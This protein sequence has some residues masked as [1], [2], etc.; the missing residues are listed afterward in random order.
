[1]IDS[2]DPTAHAAGRDVLAA[3][4]VAGV[5]S[6][7]PSTLGALARGTD[8]LQSSRAA[9]SLLIGENRSD[10]A[11]M[12][13]AIPVHATLTLGW[14]AVLA[15]TLP[16]GREPVWG[17]VA[18]LA[19]AALDLGLIGRRVPSIAALSQPGQWADHVALGLTAG[20]VL[21]RRRARRGRAWRA[22]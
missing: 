5:V 16:R 22:P 1:M 10:R 4:L 11:L 12:A 3:A 18:G 7:A 14:T 19:I 6:G 20:I 15:R 2:L 13:A 9:G 8:P 17:A 21:R